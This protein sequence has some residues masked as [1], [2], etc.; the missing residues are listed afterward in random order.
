[1]CTPGSASHDGKVHQWSL[2]AL[3][4]Q[5]DRTVLNL[6]GSVDTDEVCRKMDAAHEL[7]EPSTSA[8]EPALRDGKENSVLTVQRGGG[9]GGG[10]GGKG[11]TTLSYW[12]THTACVRALALLPQNGNGR[13]SIVMGLDTNSV[14]LLISEGATFGQQAECRLL[15]SAH[16]QDHVSC[17][18]ANSKLGLLASAGTDGTLRVWLPTHIPHCFTFIPVYVSTCYYIGVLILVC[19]LI[20]PLTAASAPVHPLTSLVFNA[21]IYL[22]VPSCA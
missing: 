21:Y 14:C 19:V 20:P 4:A 2:S 7:A 3:N 17:L 18:C 13:L 5:R 9:G 16:A 8:A 22:C 11:R 1:M 10:G 6:R 12:D 15:L